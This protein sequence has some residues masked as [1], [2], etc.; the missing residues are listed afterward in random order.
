MSRGIQPMFLSE[1]RSASRPVEACSLRLIVRPVATGHHLGPVVGEEE[2]IGLDLLLA[3]E[4]Q[5]QDAHRH[6][7]VVGGDRGHDRR[8]VAGPLAQLLARWASNRAGHE[9]RAAPA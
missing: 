1:R 6:P 7:R 5:P 9:H 4:A 8:G 2:H 3:L